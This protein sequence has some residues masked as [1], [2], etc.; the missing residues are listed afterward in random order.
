MLVSLCFQKF[1]NQNE[2]GSL[3]DLVDQLFGMA[4]HPIDISSQQGT[5]RASSGT[6]WSLPQQLRP[7]EIS[8]LP[9]TIKPSPRRSY[10]SYPF[11]PVHPPV[12]PTQMAQNN[13]KDKFLVLTIYLIFI[14]I[15]FYVV[16][17]TKTALLFEHIRFIIVYRG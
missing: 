12:P 2:R 15:Y 13:L 8:Q 3:G 10:P 1:E 9:Q 16:S 7:R 17:K 5:E 4:Q 6:G 11:P 14:V